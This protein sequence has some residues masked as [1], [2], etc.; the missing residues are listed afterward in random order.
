MPIDD[1][2][3]DRPSPPVPPS[4]P[5]ASSSPWRWVVVG[6][7][8][9]LAGALLTFWWMSRAQPPTGTPAPTEAT[10]VAV[11]SKR[12]QRQ[13][14]SLPSLE[15]SDSLLAD[16]VSGLSKHPTLA[17]LLATRGLVHGATLSVVQIGD[18]RTPATPLEVLRPATRLQL[19]GPSPAPVTPPSYARWDAA[20]AALVSVVPADAAQLYVNV[21]PLFDQAYIELGHPAGDFDLAIIAAITMLDDAPHRP[22]EPVLQRRSGGF[23]EHTDDALKALP[24]VQKQFLLIGP[25]NRRKVLAW[26]HAFAGNLDLPLR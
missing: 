16:L 23:Y 17:R 20:V 10:D 8:G 12:P 14:I 22:D 5:P 6:A 18:G 19:A 1:L 9:L 4:A 13:F 3:L 11:A 25:E 24:P 15:T 21:K 7:G 26:L 2:P